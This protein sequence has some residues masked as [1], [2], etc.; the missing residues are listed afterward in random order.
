LKKAEGRKTEAVTA[1]N[2]EKVD[3]KKEKISQISN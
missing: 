3:A 1:K 2:L